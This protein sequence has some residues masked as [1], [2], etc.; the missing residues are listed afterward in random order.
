MQI[1][2]QMLTIIFIFALHLNIFSACSWSS[3][4]YGF[5]SHL[6]MAWNLFSVSFLKKGSWEQYSLN[7]WMSKNICGFFTWGTAWQR[8]KS[9]AHTLFLKYLV[10]SVLLFGTEYCWG[11]LDFIPLLVTWFLFFWPGCSRI[12]SLSSKFDNFIRRVLELAIVGQLS[13]AHIVPSILDWNPLFQESSLQF[14]FKTCIV[15]HCFI[16]LV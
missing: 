5:P 13:L 3:F 4:C 14:Y 8:I 7:S 1:Y 2:I 12:Y 9:L 16:S 10:S 6:L 15:F 11:Q